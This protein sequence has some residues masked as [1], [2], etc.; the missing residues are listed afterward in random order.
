MI[1][2]FMAA[3]WHVKK[4]E[5]IALWAFRFRQMIASMIV[6]QKVLGRFVCIR[7]GGDLQL[8]GARGCVCT[9]FDLFPSP[10]TRMCQTLA[11]CPFFHIRITS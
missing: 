11:L 3:C 9:H 4:N 7:G 2:I 8:G 1:E 5:E 10:V 6:S